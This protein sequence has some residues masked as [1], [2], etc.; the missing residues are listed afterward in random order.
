MDLSAV[1]EIATMTKSVADAVKAVMPTVKGN[2]KAEAALSAV[3]ERVYDLQSRVIDLQAKVLEL[4][5]ENRQLG[6]KLRSAEQEATQRE[7]YEPK[8]VGQG[9]VM[10]LQGT[11]GPPY[12]CHSCLQRGNNPVQLGPLPR[13][14]HDMGTHRCPKCE[15]LVTLR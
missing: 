10:V 14:F 11:P 9:L 4:Q 6:A 13:S 2:K 7:A 8:M 5:E 12:F 15:S 1:V 3:S